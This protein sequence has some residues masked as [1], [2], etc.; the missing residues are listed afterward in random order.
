V[1]AR[2][3]TKLAAGGDPP[4]RFYTFSPARVVVAAGPEAPLVDL[5]A[6]A[7]ARGEPLQPWMTDMAEF[8]ANSEAALGW[9]GRDALRRDDL[10]PPAG[11]R[12]LAPLPRPRRNVFCVGRNFL[13]HI[14]EG[15]ASRSQA[16]EVSEV[17]IFFTKTPETVIAP[18]DTID[19]HRGVVTRL[20]YE[21]ELAVI[22][23][24]PGRGIRK[25]DVLRHIA[26]YT[27]FN[28]VT[29]RD[30]Q[31]A[32]QQWFLGKSLDASSP[33]GPA[34]VTPDEFGGLP[35]IRLRCL[36]DGEVRQNMHTDE[37]IFDVP[38]VIESL[39]RALTLRPG[40]IVATG[41]GAGVGSGFNPPRFLQAG[42]VVRC[43]GEGLLPLEN[44]VG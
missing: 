23:G 15:A 43:E 40:D 17:P 16:V 22:I 9:L 31:R 36:V 10:P 4:V 24:R 32:H 28:D 26:G 14:R 30:L 44:R 7:G 13:D 5:V 25:P 12:M 8:L 37:M 33:V 1:A 11:S 29:A 18:G 35:H 27:L 41:T 6:A 20:D 42:Q 21:C 38:T 3:G 39:S 2:P 34:I 19:P